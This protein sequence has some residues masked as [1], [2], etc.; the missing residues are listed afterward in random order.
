[1]PRPSSFRAALAGLLTVGV[2]S[3]GPAAPAAAA[4]AAPA[5]D[6]DPLVV[7]LD[8]I[9]PVLPASGDVEMSG[10]VTNVS[11]E[12]FTRINLHTFSSAQPI[13]DSLNLANSA[14]IDPTLSVGE[15][16][17]EPGTFDTVDELAPGASAT[18]T[19]SVPVEL[20]AT[21]GE[22]G[23]YWIGIHALGDSSVPRDL[24][25]D[26]RARTFIPRE[27]SGAGQAREASVILPIRS[28]VWYDE[29]GAVAGTERWARRLAEGGSLDGVLDMAD[30]AGSTPYSWLVD[31]AVLHVL[32]RLAQGNPSRTI[33]PDPTVPGQEPTPAQ[34][35][36]EG[37][38][39]P[40]P[41]DGTLTPTETV[42]TE[43]PTDEEAQL[44]ASA[45]AWLERFR[46]LVGATPVLTL[47]YGDLDVSAAVR[48]DRTRL[49]QAVA[50]GAQVMAELTL[51]TQ[52]TVAPEDDRLSP[53]AIAAVAP[54]TT[55]LLGDNAFAL[56]PTTP[57]S[58]VKLLGHE[59]VVTSTGAE[60]GGPGPT[61]ANDPLALRQRLVSEASLRLLADDTAPLVVTLPTVWRGE[62]AESFFTDLEQP[63]LD[64]VPFG[65]VAARTPKGVPA[66]SLVYTDEDVAA[67][68]GASSF[69]AVTNAAE[70]ATLLE[71]VLIAVTTL[72][73]QVRDELL[74]T[75][76]E[77]HRERPGLAVAAARRV[78]DALR[79][80]LGRI[81]VEAPP[82]VT[83]SSDSGQL[84][85]TLVNG[86]DQPVEV[87]VQVR[88]DGELTLSGGGVRRLGPQARSVVRFEAT[89][90]RAGVHN[91]Q[92]GVTS[93]DGVA[94]GSF[95]QLPIRA[96]RVSALIWIVMALG[97]LVLFGMIGY[98]LP[99]QIRA[100]RAE[101]AVADQEPAADAEPEPEPDPDPDPRADQDPAPGATV[102]AGPAGPADPE[103]GAPVER[104]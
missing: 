85:V 80:D 99:G 81:E 84:G 72:E 32:A 64:V 89:T 11:D 16:V 82:A 90:S 67:E 97:A 94:L 13:L 69:S 8:S 22:P 31:P 77:L 18:F 24:V 25:A 23:V 56:P 9:S 60:A 62:D 100:R 39:S 26:G 49:D 53:E 45:A 40:A 17:T 58:V 43:E 41:A 29:D 48:H 71:Q 47:P 42:P 37:D 87:K 103:P 46:L 88:T 66:A 51:P 68:L 30:S 54:G 96:A 101:L 4:P 83:L 21:S 38:E 65:E 74:V 104:T 59:V 36:E 27:P 102:P 5:A 91:V 7:H 57:T 44:A 50:R 10:T 19:N 55:I 35:P 20:L 63:W 93:L 61:A 34:P 73:A 78:E 12:T 98:R 79:D 52:P 33:A 1:M 95:D 70:A 3:A 92:L 76:S 15:R 75:L 14:T 2:A 28:R 86:L 6:G